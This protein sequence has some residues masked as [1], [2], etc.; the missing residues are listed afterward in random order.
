TPAYRRFSVDD[1]TSRYLPLNGRSWDNLA[2]LQPGVVTVG[3]GQGSPAF[4][5]GTGARFNVNGSRAYANSF[6][7]DGT[8]IND[9]ANGTPGGS[10]GG[11]LER[12]GIH[13]ITNQTLVIHPAFG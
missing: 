6:L 11:Q 7:L 5:F 13:G 10:A 1:G 9:H 12:G 8:D 2:L 3:A 4:D